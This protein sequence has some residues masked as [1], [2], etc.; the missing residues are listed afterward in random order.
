[1]PYVE[2]SGTL[3]NVPFVPA[4]MRESISILNFLA[5]GNFRPTLPTSRALYAS[6]NKFAAVDG[7]DPTYFP[8]TISGHNSKTSTSSSVTTLVATLATNGK[9]QSDSTL[10]PWPGAVASVGRVQ[11][12]RLIQFEPQRSFCGHLNGFPSCKDLRASTGSSS[13]S[14]PDGCPFAMTSDCTDQRS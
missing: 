7:S 11:P 1:M 6:R 5:V 2:V 13:G 10:I 14:C 4:G 12:Q 3:K 9:H 8:S